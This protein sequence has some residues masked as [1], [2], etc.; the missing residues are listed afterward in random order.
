MN[1]NQPFP[2][3]SHDDILPVLSQYSLGVIHSVNQPEQGNTSQ[4]RIVHCSTGIFV[5]RRLKSRS[6]AEMEATLSGMMADHR[7]C[8]PIIRTIHGQFF[9]VYQ[10][11][12][13]NVQLYIEPLPMA[14]HLVDYE[15]IGAK[16]ALFHTMARSLNLPVQPDRFSL[17]SAIDL[18]N[19]NHH[20]QQMDEKDQQIIRKLQSR[21]AQ[22]LPYENPPL[23]HTGYIHGDLGKWNL[24]FGKEETFL[25]DW[26]EV[27]RG[28]PHFDIAALI[29][30][31]LDLTQETRINEKYIRLFRQGY[32][33]YGQ[34]HNAVLF[35]HIQLWTVRGITALLIQRGLNN[36]AL[37]TA[38][39]LLHTLPIYQ[40]LLN[41]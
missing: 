2:D 18:L 41:I 5:V 23:P 34:I 36:A 11:N 7:I 15:Q 16:T 21:I 3:T 14:L 9:T 33:R 38:E 20:Y 24:V 40:K 37:R 31:M 8:P 6:Q 32:Q 27:R 26:G 1:S 30:S 13:Y 39:R 10:H 17:T 29:T 25:I 19:L 4:A 35:E 12:Y 22:C 28:N